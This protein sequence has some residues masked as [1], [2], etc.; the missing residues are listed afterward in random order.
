MQAIYFDTEDNSR[1]LLRVNKSGFHKRVTQIAAIKSNGD[2]WYSNAINCVDKFIE[3]IKNQEEKYIYA[4]N[5]QYDLGNLFRDNLDLLDIVMVGSRLIKARVYGKEFRDSLNLFPMSVAKLGE[6]FGKSKLGFDAHSRSYVFRDVEI[7][8]EAVTFMSDLSQRLHVCSLPSTL[9]GLSV[10]AFHAMGLENPSCQLVPIRLGIYGGRVELFDRGGEGNYQHV[11]VNSLYPSVMLQPFPDNMGEQSGVDVEF[12]IASCTVN[13]PPGDIAP[14]PVRR[15]DG[16]IYYPTGI[17]RGVWPLPELRSAISNGTSVKKFHWCYGSKTGTRYYAPYVEKMYK[18]RLK[19]QGEGNKPLSE[20]YKLLMNNLYGQLLIRGEITRSQKL[21]E[22]NIK[23]QGVTYGNKILTTHFIPL[24]EHVNYAHGAYVTSYGR[25]ALLDYARELPSKDLVYC[26]TD[27][28]FFRYHGTTRFRYSN[29]LGELK[30]EGTRSFVAPY[31]PKVYRCDDKYKAK[32]VRSDKAKDYIE[33]G[34]VEIE[35]PF[36]L[37]ESIVYLSRLESGSK[38]LERKSLSVWRK[39]VK[40]FSG[41]YDKKR[42]LKS[43]RYIPLHVNL[44]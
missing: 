4:H 15:E 28:L 17:F 33:N 40:E 2:T 41:K 19:A 11:D 22:K 12:G 21:T 3:W 29:K 8:R 13:V 5:L 24:P 39:H 1:E 30:L 18:A 7:I 34:E 16:S 37:R 43:G 42:L 38:N 14:L 23:K 36:K 20:M 27:S 26:D 9:G 35:S 44:T 25:L 6:V 31:A 10:R 32:G